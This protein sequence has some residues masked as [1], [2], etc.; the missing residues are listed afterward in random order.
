VAPLHNHPLLA[1]L[2]A[3]RLANYLAVIDLQD[4]ASG[5]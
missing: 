2:E 3:N 5:R 4:R 1:S